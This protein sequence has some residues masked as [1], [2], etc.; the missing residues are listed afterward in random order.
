MLRQGAD[1]TRKAGGSH[2]QETATHQL[3]KRGEAHDRAADFVT[4]S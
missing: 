3:R 4:K 1:D 2:R